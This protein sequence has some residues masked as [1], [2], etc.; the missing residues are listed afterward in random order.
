MCGYIGSISNSKINIDSYR[1]SNQEIVCRGPDK[2]SEL[3]SNS[4]KIFKLNNS[5]LNIL[6]IFNRL[7]ILE[8]TELGDQPMYSIDNK[9]MLLFNG[10]IYNHNNLRKNLESKGIK[11]KSKNSDSEVLFEGLSFYGVEFI[12]KLV[13]QFAITF[14]DLEKNLLYLIKDRVGQKP[15]FYEIEND[16]VI[17]SSNLKS[18]NNINNK[19][20]IS[21]SQIFNFLNFGVIPSPSTIFKNIH[22]VK[23]GTY[24]KINLEDYSY[25]EVEY[26]NPS[27]FIADNPFDE[28]KFLELFSQSVQYRL[29]SDVPVANFLSGGLDSTS[30]VKNMNENGVEDINTFTVAVNDI[31]YDESKWAKTVSEKYKTL[32]N[33]EKIDS[34]V[35]DEIILESIK[36]FDELY[37]DPSTVIS[38]LISKSISNNFK[39]AISGDGGDELL[40]GYLRTQLM[41]DRKKLPSN[42]IKALMTIYPSHFGSGQKILSNQRKSSDSYA[43]YFED[44]NLLKLMNIV[45]KNRF[46]DLYFQSS[47]QEY[48]NLLLTDYSFYLPEMMMLKVDRSSM[49][50]SL[51]V[52]SP[53]V[54][55]SLI[56]YVLSTELDFNVL[57]RKNLLK[58]Y[59]STDFN[60]DFLHR[61]KQGFVFDIENWIYSNL[62]LINDVVNSGSVVNN[63]NSNIVKILSKRKTRINALRIWKIFLLEYY[64]IDFKN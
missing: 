46:S 14:L 11:F 36:A 7:S 55:N 19:N 2:T 34:R 15:L 18:I 54:D 37:A 59:L 12:N 29:V 51:E 53:F 61:K 13:G 56:E 6:A 35:D 1:L 45:P 21:S 62:D 39:V 38:Y 17:F 42:V 24:I 49:A 25:S 58:K 48:K 26:W 40:G 41:L 44:I 30:I 33:V 5:N 64:L 47:S 4:S 31:N 28:K 22:K 43:S 60:S 52:R 50:N 57:G 3:F 16:K 8:L 20:E 9:T 63:M 23:P 27:D 32:H 10:E